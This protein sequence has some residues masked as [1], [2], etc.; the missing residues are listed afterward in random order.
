MGIVRDDE[1]YVPVQAR[2]RIPSGGLGEI[3]K[4]YRKNIFLAIGMNVRGDV[5]MKGIVSVWPFTYE[6]P[7]D[8]HLRLAH[9]SVEKK[10]RTAS[11][12]EGRYVKIQ[13]VPTCADIGESSRTAGLEACH[14]FEI[15]SDGNYLRIVVGIKWTVYGPIVGY[16]HL[17]PRRIIEN[18]GGEFTVFT[19]ES[20]SGFQQRFMA[21]RIHY[22]G[23]QHHRH[24]EDN[25]FHQSISCI[26][27]MSF[28]GRSY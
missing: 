27:L 13:P 4:P 18:G 9:R 12:T 2:S 28:G 5:E 26:W 8:I 23:G 21:L 3:L 19:C 16:C 11:L 7:V 10:F 1:V 22:R 15:L 20:P 24:Q 14:P 17:I 25:S 6:L